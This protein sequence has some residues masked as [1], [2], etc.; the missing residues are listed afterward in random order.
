MGSEGRASLTPSRLLG[1]AVVLLSA[2][3][4]ALIY[5]AASGGYFYVAEAVEILFYQDYGSFWDLLRSL[6][7]YPPFYPS[8]L[9]LTYY[10][11]ELDYALIV[12]LNALFLV[13]GAVYVYLL[14]RREFGD[15]EAFVAFAVFIASVGGFLHFLTT[16]R[17]APMVC[18]A[19][20]LVFHL[21]EFFRSE[22]S[23]KRKAAVVHIA[24]AGLFASLGLLTKWTFWIYV[25][26]PVALL[27]IY[28]LRR[29]LGIGSGM[30]LTYAIAFA[31]PLVP[32]ALWYA[33][34]I[35]WSAFFKTRLNEPI[36]PELYVDR[37]A[38]YAR[39]VRMEHLGSLGVVLLVALFA[40]GIAGT[41]KSPRKVKH[42]LLL[43]GGALFPMLVL[44]SFK[45]L[46]EG[47]YLLPILYLF[48]LTA[49]WGLNAV[50][51]SKLKAALSVAALVLIAVNWAVTAAR[52]DI[53]ALRSRQVVFDWIKPQSARILD[54]IL[55]LDAVPGEGRIK[56]AVHPFCF[57]YHSELHNLQMAKIAHRRRYRRIRFAGY[58]KMEYNIFLEEVRRRSMDVI[59]MN[60]LCFAD[61]YPSNIPDIGREEKWYT[62]SGEVILLSSVYDPKEREILEAGYA[63]AAS[64]EAGSETVHIWLK[65]TGGGTSARY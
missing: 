3:Y 42:L 13:G 5:R 30:W 2:A 36:A 15:V 9:Y 10:A 28:N 35:N 12:A 40:V 16:V 60:Q 18:F 19:P 65:A 4:L 44:A 34:A 49:A 64:V 31:V 8:F 47:R 41:L 45:K 61:D 54:A 59:V 25:A 62:A 29:L 32:T 53:P 24:L 48:A 51:R 39:L 27:A 43:A 37:F 46:I 52:L 56:V 38:E 6:D 11:L 20:A 57:D 22:A 7:Y 21:N 55:K 33:T 63:P 17:D 14:A 26:V 58:H 23:G 50:K 1:L